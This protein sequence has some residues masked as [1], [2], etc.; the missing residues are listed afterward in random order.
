MPSTR[1][2]KREER[3]DGQTDDPTP[4]LSQLSVCSVAL[5]PTGQ[6]PFT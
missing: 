4:A 6:Q 1:D 5:P 3:K 2:V